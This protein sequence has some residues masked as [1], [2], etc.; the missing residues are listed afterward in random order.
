MRS[1]SIDT[2]LVTGASSGIGR[3]LAKCFAAEGCRLVLLAR[4]RHALQALADELHQAHRTQAEVLP[5][6]LA[7]PATPARICEHLRLNG[8]KVDVLVNNAG[9]G[10]Y[11]QFAALP[12]E[13]QLEMMQVN[14]T[15][16]MHLTR[17]LLPGMI[18]RRHGG[19][20][21]VAST[22]AFQPGPGM[23][24]YYAT[25][26]FVLSF[27]EAIAEELAETGVSVTAL[28]PGATATNFAQAASA[29]FSRLFMRSA[30]SAE[31]VA[32]IGHNAFRKGQVVA[33]AGT[34]N[35]LLGLAVRLAPRSMV[36]KVVKRLNAV[37][38]A[39]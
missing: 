9:L 3:E 16:V 6:D 10:A 23:A 26:A 2:V 33:I 7:Q 30:M 20:L 19:I 11:G 13:R 25:K 12:V 31:S 21:N 28:C 37:S 1:A 36:R 35:R 8:T 4:K 22:A 24:V 34:R 14:V 18:Q 5:A 32:R 29:Q 27:S 17:L 15:T 39:N 38:V